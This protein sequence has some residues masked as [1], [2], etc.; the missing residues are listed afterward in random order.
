MLVLEYGFRAVKMGKKK[1]IFQ[2]IGAVKRIRVRKKEEK[3][4]PP[5][6]SKKNKELEKILASFDKMDKDF[7]LGEEK[8]TGAVSFEHSITDLEFKLKYLSLKDVSGKDYS[9]SFPTFNSNI[10]I[11]DDDGRYFFATKAGLNQISGDLLSFFEMNDLKP[12]D[13][14]LVDYDSSEISG[15][16][17]YVVHIKKK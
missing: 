16:G 6:Q 2:K 1:T 10:L 7:G 14:I 12:G 13:T 4:A 17:R 8:T 5:S 3:F 9:R 15:D 11:I